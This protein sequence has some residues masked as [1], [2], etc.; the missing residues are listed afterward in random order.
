MY[1]KR[2]FFFGFIVFVSFDSIA[3]NQQ[4]LLP[5][6]E[7]ERDLSFVDFRQQ[8]KT[9][10]KNRDPEEFVKFVSQQVSGTGGKRGMRNFV[11]F[12]K[13]EAN[14]SELWPIMENILDLGG[15]FVRSEQGVTFCAPYVFTNFPDDLDIYGH[16]AIIADKVPLKSAPTHT[17]PNVALLSYNL[18]KVEDWRSVVEKSSNQM[19]SWIKVSTMDGQKGYVNKKMVRSPTDYS[20]C[21]LFTPKTGWKIISLVSGG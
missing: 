16:G 18:L 17:A 15:G 3:E 11:K 4:R 1:F 10:V 12:W 6:D 21:F 8:L 7:A 13:P 5:V 9:T 19:T 2:L 14:D 20:A